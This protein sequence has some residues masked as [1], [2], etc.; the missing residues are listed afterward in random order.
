MKLSKKELQ[1][2]HDQIKGIANVYSHSG[3]HEACNK[4]QEHVNSLED[5]SSNPP[6]NPPPPPGPSH[7]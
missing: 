5:D 1:N 3:L 2:L 7:G 6:G 4:L